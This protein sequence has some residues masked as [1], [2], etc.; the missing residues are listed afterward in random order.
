MT[1]M[2]VSVRRPVSA[3]LT[4][5]AL[6][7]TMIVVAGP[8]EAS[9]K[10]AITRQPTSV[11]AA[12]GARVT[13]VVKVKK[14]KSA[15]KAIKYQWQRR[16]SG[17][18]RAVA[19]AKRSKYALTSRLGLNGTKY[20]VKVSSRGKARYSRTATLSVVDPAGSR[21]NPVPVGAA[22]TSGVWQFV[23]EPTDTDAWPEISSTNMFDDP[24]PPGH[25]YVTVAASVSYRGKATGSPWLNTSA[26]FLGSNGVVYDA[27][28]DDQ[29][30][31]AVPQTMS[32]VDDMSPGSSARGR[33]CAVVPTSVIGG[34][35]WLV[36]GDDDADESGRDVFVR[37]S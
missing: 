5:V 33:Y 27:S 16:T 1:R 37:L 17:S 26:E 31:G 7:A 2:H 32:D 14:P 21:T 15:K 9:S 20:R 35:L 12:P 11:T 29:W 23:L 3:C 6:I 22:F 30:C 24:P 36:S 28:S 10:P 34:G 19:G 13:F 25:S 4:M 18:W 8:A